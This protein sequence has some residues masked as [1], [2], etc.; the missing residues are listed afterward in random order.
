VLVVEEDLAE[1][2]GQ[3]GL[4]RAGGTEEDEAADG[5]IDLDAIPNPLYIMPLKTT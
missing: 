4:A 2:L 5:K 3:F 1:R